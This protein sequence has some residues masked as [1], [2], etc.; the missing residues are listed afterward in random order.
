[1]FRVSIIIERKNEY[2]EKEHFNAKNKVKIFSL[3][4]FRF[5]IT[6][7]LIGKICVAAQEK[8]FEYAQ[9]KV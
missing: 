7:F 6:D 3:F 9:K 4:Q 5:Q 1:M 2:A 8:K